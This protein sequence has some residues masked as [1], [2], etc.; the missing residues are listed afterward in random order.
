MY[1][2]KNKNINNKN[3]NLRIRNEKLY[4]RIRLKET[5]LQN[6]IRRKLPLFRHICRIDKNRKIK[7]IMFRIVDGKNK[8]G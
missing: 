6:V 8:K 1:K 3:K 2:N 4:N 5:V 7:D